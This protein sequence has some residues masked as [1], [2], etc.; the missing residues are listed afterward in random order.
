ME[1]G[2]HTTTDA[3]DQ[4]D[5]VI[6]THAVSDEALEAAAG[7]HGL[8]QSNMPCTYQPTNCRCE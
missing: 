4:A 5:E 8:A 7:V 2:S 3:L 6:L 1:H